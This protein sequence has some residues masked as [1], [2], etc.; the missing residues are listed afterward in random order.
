MSSI[1]IR[2][3][4]IRQGFSGPNESHNAREN[5]TMFEMPII[6]SLNFKFPWG[7]WNGCGLI[8]RR[9]ARIGCT[10]VTDVLGKVCADNRQSMGTFYGV[11]PRN[12]VWS[13][14]G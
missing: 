10:W 12:W 1:G 8:F 7:D 5:Y 11:G 9:F 13:Y 6:V 4:G 2:R 14:V 3:D